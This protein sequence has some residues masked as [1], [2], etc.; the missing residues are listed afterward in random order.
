MLKFNERLKLISFES[1]M[2][3]TILSVFFNASCYVV[4]R[5]YHTII[6]L[7]V[8]QKL[9]GFQFYSICKRIRDINWLCCIN[10][11][12]INVLKLKHETLSFC[13]YLLIW[14]NTLIIY[15]LVW[16]MVFSNARKWIRRSVSLSFESKSNIIYQYRI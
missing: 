11:F 5:S 6:S 8:E 16:A 9:V 15:W 1:I 4:Y 13:T 14:R 10:I 3:V 2:L 12:W 7:R